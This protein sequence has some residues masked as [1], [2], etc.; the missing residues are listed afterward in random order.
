M[1]KNGIKYT[2][3]S[4]LGLVLISLP[5]LLS[6]LEFFSEDLN[7]LVLIF[8]VF[9]LSV[10]LHGIVSALTLKGKARLVYIIAVP[11]YSALSLP[12]LLFLVSGGTRSF[13][14]YM[15]DVSAIFSY[16]VFIFTLGVIITGW[17]GMIA[18]SIF[19]KLTKK[20]E[21]LLSKANRLDGK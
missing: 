12:T 20:S 6:Q 5:F 19:K 10:F 8:I 18:V 14:N 9:P 16:P 4:V 7:G 13:E 17:L 21:A 15:N 1:S 3:Y 11:I 2:V